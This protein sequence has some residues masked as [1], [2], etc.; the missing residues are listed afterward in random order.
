MFEWYV[1]YSKPHAERQV[2]NHL[3][4]RGFEVFFPSTPVAR[5]RRGRPAW[6]AYFPCYLFIHYDM[7]A[8]GMSRLIYTPGL[9][10]LVEFGGEPATLRAVDVERIRA[11]LAKPQVWDE[12]G[13][14]LLPG[15]PVEI[16]QEPFREVDA[17]FDRRLTP[18]ARVRVFLR[19]L[20]QHTLERHSVERLV[21]LVLDADQ[22]RKK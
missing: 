5:P 11:E 16:L 13:E 20:E 22:V 1:L 19:Y 6:R 4:E 15:D 18:D 12:A 3:Q 14:A 7:G 10:G 21:A 9:R 8:A 17:V 2:A